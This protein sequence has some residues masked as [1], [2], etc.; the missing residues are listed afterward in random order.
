MPAHDLGQ[1]EVLGRVDRRDAQLDEPPAV[2]LGDDPADDH[3]HVVEPGRAEAVEHVGDQLHV[4]AGQDREPDAVHVLGHRG[5]HDLLRRQPDALVD[6]LEARVPGADGDLLGA[7]GVPVEARAC[8]RAAAA[9]RRAPRRSPGP[10]RGPPP[11]R[12]RPRRRRPRRR[13]RS[14][15]GTRRTPRAACR[16]TPPWSRPRG[17]RPA[18]RAIR[19][20]SVL[21]SAASAA[22]AA[23]TAASSRCA[24]QRLDRVAARTRSASRVGGHDRGVEVGGQRRRLGGLERC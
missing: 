20:A 24:F 21:A 10:A 18:W 17:P 15:R 8:R 23:V 6:H 13:P 14:G 9:G 4:R 2:G 22:S 19:F 12:R 11:A 3:R 16:P 1:A 5:G 7:V